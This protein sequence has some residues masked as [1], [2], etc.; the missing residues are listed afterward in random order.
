[1]SYQ[2]PYPTAQ[3]H[4]ALTELF[5]NLYM[6]KGSVSIKAPHLRFGPLTLTFS[7]NMFIVREGKELT[8]INS[9]RLSEAGSACLSA[10]GEIKNV[11]R[12]AGFHGMDDPFYKSRYAAT[13]YSVDAPYTKGLVRNPSQADS[14][15]EP[16]VILTPSSS[17]PIQNASYQEISSASPKDGVLTLH[18][19]GGIAISGDSFQ[20]WAR[21]DEFFNTSA[22]ISMGLAGFFKPTSIGPGWRNYAKPDLKELLSMTQS[23][24]AHLLPGHGEPVINHA[25]AQ[26]KARLERMVK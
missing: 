15:F 11:V 14:Y 10:L 24:F 23:S 19:E 3:P 13:V 18:R 2:N 26:F 17:L 22:K 12:L 5:P 21:P 6:I 25:S 4:G 20:N 9:V 16:D 8:L 1:M 7:R